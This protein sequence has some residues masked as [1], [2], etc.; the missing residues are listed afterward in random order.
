M[1]KNILQ[2]G[3]PQTKT[4]R[5]GIACW[6]P[7]VTRKLRICNTYC[8]SNAKMLHERATMLRYKYI[9]CLFHINPYRTNVENRVSS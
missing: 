2:P 5:M 1:G 9:G 7:K 6:I 4:W 3:M 8:F